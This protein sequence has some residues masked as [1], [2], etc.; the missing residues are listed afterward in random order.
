MSMALADCASTSG[1]YCR[2]GSLLVCTYRMLFSSFM[3]FPFRNPTTGTP[4][5][6][7]P[8]ANQ[9][10]L[11]FALVFDRDNFVAGTLGKPGEILLRGRIVCEHFQHASHLNTIHGLPR[12]EELSLIHISE[13]TRLRR[14]SYA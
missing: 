4:A 6:L 7:P 14:I 8:L 3:S 5:V 11:V 12:L 2:S 9:E 1:A 13:P 10:T